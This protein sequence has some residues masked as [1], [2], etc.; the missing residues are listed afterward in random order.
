MLGMWNYVETLCLSH[1]FR[2]LELWNV[3]TL[4]QVCYKKNRHYKLENIFFC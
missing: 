2:F 3:G 4:L 1:C